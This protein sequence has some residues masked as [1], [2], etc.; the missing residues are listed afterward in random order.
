MRERERE[1]ERK[2]ERCTQLFFVV[3][4]DLA[5]R[6]EKVEKIDKITSIDIG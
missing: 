2:R 1:R 5:V 4:K 6:R 3:E